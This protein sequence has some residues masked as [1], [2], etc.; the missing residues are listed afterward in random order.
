MKTRRWAVAGLAVAVS[1]AFA[2]GCG[3][4]SDEPGTTPSPTP[5]NPKDA[6]VA[7][8]AEIQ[9][10]SFTFDM[11]ATN[12]TGT[13][14]V[15]PAAK[16]AAVKLNFEE[17]GVKFL[18][19][20]LILADDNYM[21]I[22][23]GGLK[24]PGMPPPDKWQHIDRTKLKDQEALDLFNIDDADPAG[25]KDIFNAIVNVESAG[26]RKYKG[27]V[28]LTKAT[29]AGIV[30]EDVVKALGEQA[31]AVPFEAT[32]D[33]KGRLASLRLDIPAAGTAKAQTWEINYSNYGT[34]PKLEKP[35]ASEVQE[36]SKAVYD[37]LN[38]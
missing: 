21:K 28:D 37:M 38:S 9:K 14:S 33:D 29:D 1:L 4:D 12:A 36:A 23:F 15:D 6:L 8:V 31:K 30:D 17:S 35:P 24:V 34:A 27:T 16:S 26:E 2:T 18:M 22:D 19:E 11:K 25:A 7:S 20:L 10:N 5:P 32:V 3:K 13:G